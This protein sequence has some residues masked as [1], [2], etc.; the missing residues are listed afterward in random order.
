MVN[1]SAVDQFKISFND[2]Q[3]FQLIY[4][5]GHMLESEDPNPGFST[6]ASSELATDF[7]SQI[8]SQQVAAALRSASAVFARMDR[9]ASRDMICSILEKRAELYEEV[10]LTPESTS[11]HPTLDATE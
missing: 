8:V 10:N 2:E 11:V 4:A 6:V 1:S 7:F 5:S 3:Y 9:V